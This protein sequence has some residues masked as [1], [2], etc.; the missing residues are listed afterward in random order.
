MAKVRVLHLAIAVVLSAGA[1][2]GETT[3]QAHAAE[4]PEPAV[5]GPGPEGDYLRLVHERLHPAWVD[6]FIRLSAYKA[7]GPASSNR[8]AEVSIAIRWDGTVNK[9]QISKS[10]GADDFDEAALNAVWF[11]APFPPPVQVMADD[12]L[13]HLKW[14]FA[15]N[16]RLCSGA[17]IVRVEYPLNIALPQLA[18]R[19]QLAEA[20]R[21][22]RDQVARDGWTYDFLTPFIRQ[23]LG[24][25]NLSSALD[26]RS[27][28]ALAAAGDG[29]QVRLL[30]TMLF[31]PQSAGVAAVALDRLGIDVG[32]L[33][34][35]ALAGDGA[36][37]QRQAVLAAIRALPS[38]LAHCERCS[39]VLAAAVLDPRHPARERAELI[40]LLEGVPITETV[41]KAL[42]SAAKDSNTAV[43]GAAMLA[44]V[45]RGQGRVGVIRMAALLR[46][47]APEMRA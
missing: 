28:G 33:L 16:H 46:D 19:G 18:A 12:G 21:R 45:P 43:R 22:M 37:R 6:G 39:E 34:T 25:P 4:A 10:S 42:A 27:A 13:V 35:K 47:P 20:I 14:V 41:G 36:D 23:W 11:A 17:Q 44:Q 3:R 29:Q 9:A 38:T 2:A 15:R 40:G 5:G 8:Q 30:E 32:A 24:R 7:L 26:A 1:L 31:A